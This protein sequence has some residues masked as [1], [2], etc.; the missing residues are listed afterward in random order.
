MP[1]R[2][3]LQEPERLRR[4]F[5]QVLLPGA[6]AG[7]TGA[8]VMVVLAMLTSAIAGESAFRPACHLNRLLSPRQGS[9]RG[10]VARPGHS[11]L[12]RAAD[13]P[14]LLLHLAFDASFS[15][16]AWGSALSTPHPLSGQR[17]SAAGFESAR[18]SRGGARGA[19][20]D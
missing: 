11:H 1:H 20:L 14:A 13:A 18:G 10:S 9:Q 12:E 3:T 6:L 2:T 17:N 15:P 19:L 7:L 16:A 4:L 5:T 8:G